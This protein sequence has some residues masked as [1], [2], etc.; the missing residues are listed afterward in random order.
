[1][2]Y[3]IYQW[4]GYIFPLSDKGVIPMTGGFV[5]KP[6]DLVF[7]RGTDWISRE[8]EEVTHNTYSHVAIAT[9]SWD[10]AKKL[11]EAQGFRPVGYQRT[12]AY[13]GMCDVYRNPL[14]VDKERICIVQNAREHLG[15]R[16]DYPLIAIELIR[17]TFGIT[18][19]WYEY[20]S[21]IC[22]TL[23]AI[24]YRKYGLDPCP[25]IKNPSPADEATS[26]MFCK[27]GSF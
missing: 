23:A 22:S 10:P 25:G 13:K 4:M 3:P 7:V 16:Y 19:P 1:M 12:D 6:A 18:L 2:P 9:D 15:E 14:L 26:R 21:V 20:H 8:I 11:I 27:V 24:A 5:L 17:Y